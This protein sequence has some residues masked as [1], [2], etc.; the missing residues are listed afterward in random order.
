M[1]RWSPLNERQLALLDRLASGKESEEPWDPGEFRTAYALRDRGLVTIKRSGGEVE[2]QVTEAGTF[3]IQHGHHP[4]DPAHAGE[5]KT[6]KG[7]ATGGTRSASYADRPVALARRAKAKELI[8]RLVTDRRA[9]FTKP[10]DATVT[11]WRRVIDYAKRHRLIPE[12]KRIE[13][14]RMWN[15]D[16]QISLVEGPHPNSLR[17]RPDEA[18]PVHVPTQ[19]RSPHPVVAALR[20]DEGRLVMP[21]PL[22]RRS[23]LLL[24]G[25]AAEAVRRGHKVAEH[26]VPSRRRSRAYTT[27]D[28]RHHPS[29]YSLREGELDLVVDGFTYTVTIQQESP[30]STDPERSKSLVIELG[31]SRSS[32]QSRWADRKRWVLEDILGAILREIETRALEDA[33]RKADEERA[34][35]EREVRWRAAMEKAKE[36][37]AQEQ[38]AEVLRA[39]TCQWQEAAD[40]S[41]YCDALERRLEDP[42]GQ[43]E[44]A[45]DSAQRWL[46]WARRYVQSL[47]PLTR[48]PAMPTAREPKP[49]ELAPYLNGWSPHGP[50]AHRGWGAR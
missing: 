19:L 12:G 2:A 39:Q 48:L 28:G 16:L 46:T 1:H 10:D 3:Y 37:A 4:D 8:E 42:S 40:L 13:S 47:D 29:S 18:P 9:T 41:A 38:Y 25:L 31:Y 23:L 21:A 17:Q 45:V 22:R 49:E 7:K 50:E 32:R 33:Q 5:E 30:Q 6:A 27:Y 34:K 11:E 35:A 26:E 20:D 24:Q 36:L 14:L 43:D 15:R 44:T